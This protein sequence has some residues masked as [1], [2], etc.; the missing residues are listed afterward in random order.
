MILGFLGALV[1]LSPRLAHF[2]TILHLL[3]NKKTVDYYV[4]GKRPAREPHFQASMQS[5]NYEKFKRIY[6]FLRQFLYVPESFILLLVIFLLD[7]LTHSIWFSKAAILLFGLA[8]PL[9][10]FRS[11]VQ[12]LRHDRLEQECLDFIKNFKG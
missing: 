2:E 7:I 8:Q 10:Y 5:G 1:Y 3:T 12:T 11:I 9:L 4:N 6:R